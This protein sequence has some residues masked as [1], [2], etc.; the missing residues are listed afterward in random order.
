MSR[1]LEALRLQVSSVGDFCDHP[2]QTAFIPTHAV[3][4]MDRTTPSPEVGLCAE[5]WPRAQA[6]LF[7]SLGGRE[8][9]SLS[10]LG[11]TAALVSVTEGSGRPQGD[12]SSDAHP[13]SQLGNREGMTW[14]SLENAGWGPSHG[15]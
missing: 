9:V 15:L 11:V 13:P 2:V 1:G 12:K 10:P 3:S 6:G 7:L 14:I 5:S 4:T 8:L